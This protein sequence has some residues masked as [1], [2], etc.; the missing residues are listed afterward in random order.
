MPKQTFLWLSVPIIV[1]CFLLPYLGLIHYLLPER[2]S[3]NDVQSWSIFLRYWA[4]YWFVWVPLLGFTLRRFVFSAG[5]GRLG[6][7]A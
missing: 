4:V 6:Q 5:S 1:C 7:D 3:H 2:G